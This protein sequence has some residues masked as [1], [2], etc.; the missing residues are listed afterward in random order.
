MLNHFQPE[1][2][3][4]MKAAESALCLI[5]VTCYINMC[6]LYSELDVIFYAIYNNAYYVLCY[7]LNNFPPGP[8]KSLSQRCTTCYIIC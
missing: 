4:R 3:T 8:S 5:Y 2:S 7:I 1:T 6:I